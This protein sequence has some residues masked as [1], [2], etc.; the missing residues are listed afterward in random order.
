MAKYQ[1]HHE[2]TFV[3]SSL[4][5]SV[6][7]FFLFHSC[8]LSL[9]GAASSIVF[10]VTKH[11]F[12]HNKSMLVVTKVLSQIKIRLLRQNFCVTTNIILSQQKF[13]YDK[14][15]F[16]AP[17]DMFCC[18]KLVFA[19]TKVSFMKSILLLQ[20]MPMT[21]ECLAKPAF[22]LALQLHLVTQLMTKQGMPA[23]GN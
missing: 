5:K 16:V 8:R 13:C 6:S 9:V 3:C 21:Q 14:H 17:K 1:I 10:V 15:T 23:V 7:F 11:V 4:V 20:C 22:R 18:D 2:P 19:V 12:C